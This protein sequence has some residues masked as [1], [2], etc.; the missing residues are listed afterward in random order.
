MGSIKVGDLMTRR[1]FSALVWED[2]EKVYRIMRDKNVRHVPVIDDEGAVVGIISQRDLLHDI[3]HEDEELPYG[4]LVDVMRTIKAGEVMTAGVECADPTQDAVDAATTLLENKLGCL[5][6]TDGDVLVGILT[7]S[8]FVK[9]FV[10]ENAHSDGDEKY[11]Y[12]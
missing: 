6:V 8:D 7:E 2:V 1:V 9:R 3:L 11:A 4:T 12:H 10:A 5:P